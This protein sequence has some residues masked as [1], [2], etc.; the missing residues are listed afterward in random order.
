MEFLWV[1]HSVHVSPITI[2]RILKQDFHHKIRKLTLVCTCAMLMIFF[3]LFND[4]RHPRYFIDRLK[5]NS[6]LSFTQEPM[7]GSE[8][9][10][11]DLKLTLDNN[12]CIQTSVHVKA[13][14]RGAYA[15]F[16]SHIPLQYKKSV[17]NSL[18]NRAIKFTSSN[19]TLKLELYRIQQV[20]AN[21]DY[22]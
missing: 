22:P 18:V 16:H 2:C 8:F 21:N 13:T 17:I 19:E 14:D 1:L 9:N 4:K 7:I 12:R 20:L 11:L 3:A 15:N 5:L 6:A 10:F